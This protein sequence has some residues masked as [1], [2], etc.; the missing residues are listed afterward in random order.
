VD[1]IG[2]CAWAALTGWLLRKDM[3]V[4]GWWGFSSG[5]ALAFWML[6][7]PLDGANIM[8]IK[9]NS[10]QVNT[11]MSIT[12][13]IAILLVLRLSTGRAPFKQ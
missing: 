6:P 2:A 8:G 12:Y 1:P 11:M 4:M 3:Y 10:M 7:L 9:A 13:Q 5:I